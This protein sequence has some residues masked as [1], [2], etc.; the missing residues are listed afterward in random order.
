[1]AISCKELKSEKPP[2]LRMKAAEQ[3]RETVELRDTVDT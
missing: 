1:M 3:N 2:T